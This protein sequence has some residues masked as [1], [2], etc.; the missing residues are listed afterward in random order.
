MLFWYL[1]LNSIELNIDNE[2]VAS[3][4]L[5]P[6]LLGGSEESPHATRFGE[7]VTDDQL[8]DW[9][10][11]LTI[12]DSCI[13]FNYLC[14]HRE[15][16]TLTSGPLL[17]YLVISCLFCLLP[18]PFLFPQPSTSSISAFFIAISFRVKSQVNDGNLVGDGK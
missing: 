7:T 2:V 11:K 6:P 14:R 17:S 13:R 1:I 4:H 5:P 18:F 10:F 3:V 12:V 16:G 15:Y 9:V 8:N